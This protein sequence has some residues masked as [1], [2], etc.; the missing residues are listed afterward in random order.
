MTHL[1]GPQVLAPR[2]DLGVR[3]GNPKTNS[4]VIVVATWDDPGVNPVTV[5]VGGGPQAITMLPV[6]TDY[7]NNTEGGVTPGPIQGQVGWVGNLEVTGLNSFPQANPYTVA[8]TGR[9]STTGN[10]I[11]APVAG[12][13][14]TMFH[15]TCDNALGSIRGASYNRIEEPHASGMWSEVREEAESNITQPVSCVSMCDDVNGYVDQFWCDDTVGTGATGHRSTNAVWSPAA[16]IQYSFV[17]NSALAYDYALAYF[18]ALG[19]GSM[20]DVSQ[21]GTGGERSYNWWGRN[22]D[23]LWCQHNIPFL[24][25]YGDHEVCQDFGMWSNTTAG[26]SPFWDGGIRTG[27]NPATNDNGIANGPAPDGDATP[28]GWARYAWASAINECWAMFM[29]PL[30]GSQIGIGPENHWQTL[31]GGV[32]VIS[33]DAMYNGTGEGRPGLVTMLGTSQITELKSAIN[34]SADWYLWHVPFGGRNY[35]AGFSPIDGYNWPL[36][37]LVQTEYDALF[38]AVDGIGPLADKSVVI[39]GDLHHLYSMRYNA[40]DE[41]GLLWCMAGTMSGSDNVAVVPQDARDMTV[42]YDCLNWQGVGDPKS[43]R[44]FGCVKLVITD[45]LS[46]YMINH[47]ANLEFDIGIDQVLLPGQVIMG[48]TITAVSQEQVSINHSLTGDEVSPMDVDAST[49][50]AKTHKDLQR[51][52]SD[53]GTTIGLIAGGPEARTNIIFY[54]SDLP[55]TA[56][57][58]PQG[59]IGTVPINMKPGITSYR[60]TTRWRRTTGTDNTCEASAVVGTGTYANSV[61]A[62]RSYSGGELSGVVTFYFEIKESGTVISVYNDQDRTYDERTGLTLPVIIGPYFFCSAADTPVVESVI[63]EEM[64]A[65]PR[66]LAPGIGDF[67]AL[68]KALLSGGLT[69]AVTWPASRGDITLGLINTANYEFSQG[70][71]IQPFGAATADSDTTFPTGSWVTDGSKSVIAIITGRFTDIDQ[72]FRIGDTFDFITL[73]LGP[74]TAIQNDTET[75]LFGTSSIIDASA[76]A[77]VIP[78]ADSVNIAQRVVIPND[79]LVAAEVTDGSLFTEYTIPFHWGNGWTSER[80]SD[81]GPWPDIFSIY[82]YEFA[83]GIPSDYIEQIEFMGRKQEFG[84]APGWHALD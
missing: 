16:G 24:P 66:Q 57:E 23:R 11:C 83:D 79:P 29:S 30:Q 9:T 78:F 68:K 39:T 72:N 19:M 43:Q 15:G 67:P 14:H 2:V 81:T 52:Y 21:V 44:G 20:D 69:D 46:V 74:S 4:V 5:D 58:I 51:L 17:A 40:V 70:R 59:T 32:Q 34:P 8:Q 45:D 75:N 47:K 77:M 64:S 1:T 54:A 12:Q 25:Q 53:L 33:P 7:A 82:Y 65:L 84:P 22:A 60:M 42:E 62:N 80:A 28:G 6:G 49:N 35:S 56:G 73:S 10:F 38:T 31:I 13:H 27:A 50:V 26:G 63:I 36:Y 76:I 71:F 37:D 18:M 48:K 3:Y 55:L 41:G 61:K